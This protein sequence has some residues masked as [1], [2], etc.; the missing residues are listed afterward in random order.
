MPVP[1]YIRNLRAKIGHELLPVIGVTAIVINGAGEILLQRRSDNGTWALPGGL[2]EPGE[3]PGDAVIREVWE[4][5]GVTVR[6]E[7]IIG[8]YSGADY[9][10]RYPNG[11][12]SVVLS[13]SFVC[14]PVEGEPHVHD[15]ESLEVRYF[16]PDALPPLLERH[17]YR[18]QRALRNEQRADF[19]FSVSSE[20][21]SKDKP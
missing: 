8:I 10:I 17:Q 16:A 21:L 15:D 3:H 6:P 1:D 11:D 13:V 5:T 18:I 20:S 9:M 2:I 14:R 19:R 7:R 4:E 12:E